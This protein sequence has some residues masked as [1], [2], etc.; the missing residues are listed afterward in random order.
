MYRLLSC[1]LLVAFAAVF[2]SAATAEDKLKVLII[3]GQNNH[4]AWP[5]TTVMMKQY[6]EESGRF[7]VD[8]ERTKY[9][10]KGGDLLTEYPLNDGKTYEDLREPKTDPDFKPTFSNY[11]VV[12]SN[13]G[14]NAAQWP[15]ETQDALTEFVSG[16]GGTHR[17]GSENG[18]E[19]CFHRNLDV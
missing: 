12:L 9:T 11:D 14:F 18:E 7:T 16:G 8:V 1:T 15:K 6:L 2:V 17:S 3:D 5:K 10:W 19:V 4:T 13:F